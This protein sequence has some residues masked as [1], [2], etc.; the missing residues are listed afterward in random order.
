M[1]GQFAETSDIPSDALPCWNK[2]RLANLCKKRT[3]QLSTTVVWWLR[4]MFCRSVTSIGHQ[5]EEQI[6]HKSKQTGTINL[7]MLNIKNSLNNHRLALVVCLKLK[8]LQADC[9][10]HV[11]SLGNGYFHW[12]FGKNT[13]RYIVIYHGLIDV[14]PNLTASE[15]AVQVAFW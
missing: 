15:S 10:I 2:C 9:S 11:H 13:N 3:T 12:I 14:L 8:R 6:K 5:G 7:N 4:Q 1:L